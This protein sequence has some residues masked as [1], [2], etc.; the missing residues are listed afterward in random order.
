MVLVAGAITLLAFNAGR[1][2]RSMGIAGDPGTATV[3]DC[4]QYGGPKHREFECHGDFRGEG[5]VVHRGVVFEDSYEHDNGKSFQVRYDGD[6]AVSIEDIATAQLA[7]MLSALAV[8]LLGLAAM[9]AVIA[10]GGRPGVVV[11][12]YRYA[13]FVFLGGMILVIASLLVLMGSP[14]SSNI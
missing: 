9:L 3:T 4:H 14:M 2:A 11:K 10:I 6:G 7:P 13:G 8:P 12:V 5:G 1:V